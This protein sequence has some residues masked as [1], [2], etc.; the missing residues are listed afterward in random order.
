MMKGKRLIMVGRW[1]FI[2]PLG[3]IYLVGIAHR[4]G[5]EIRIHLVKGSDFGSLIKEVADFKPDIVGFSVW[6]GQHKETFAAADR[7]ME[8]GVRVAMGGPH[9]TYFTEECEGHADWVVRGEGFRNFRLILENK[10]PFGMHFDEVRMAEGFPIPQRDIVYEQYSHFAKSP[11]KSIMCSIGCPFNCSYCF[12]SCYNKMYGGFSLYLRSVDEIID[13]V[14]RIRDNYPLELIYVQDDVF[15]IDLNWLREFTK[16]WNTLVKVPLHGQIRLELT[17]S[18]E[19]LD[20]FKEA[21]FT[22]FTFAIEHG[23]DWI[24]KFVLHRAMEN[25]LIHLGIEK[26]KKRG[27]AIRTEQMYA[28]PLSDISGDLET[29]ELNVNLNPDMMWSTIFAPCLGTAL[30]EMAANLGIYRSR[31][32]DDIDTSYWIK[33]VLHHIA[34]GKKLFEKPVLECATGLRDNPLARMRAVPADLL[35]A[36]IYYGS[37]ALFRIEYLNPLNNARYYDQATMLQCLSG[38]LSKVCQGYKL[39]ADF[40]NLPKEEWTWHR[41]GELTVKHLD[42][43]GLRD[44]REI[45]R[46]D[47]IKLCGEFMAGEIPKK[48]KDNPY[49]FCYFPAGAIL[50]QKLQSKGFFESEDWLLL[51]AISRN[52]LFEYGLY[53]IK[54]GDPP[55]VIR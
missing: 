6:T 19:R 5:W 3:I 41:L 40:I 4:L 16:K 17:N 9:A 35:S 42:G 49:Y 26:L 23:N 25:K 55:I 37:D 30:G 44:Q 7:I 47:F 38:W 27:F 51:S 20:L 13:E 11:I 45:W 22:G 15:G 10:L 1:E 34:G 32:S 52:H 33:G 53:K 50:A 46:H 14:L 28:L 31:N 24:R 36:D 43:L 54:K 8:M 21:G 29:L 18:E 12:A 39:A 48:I 2:E